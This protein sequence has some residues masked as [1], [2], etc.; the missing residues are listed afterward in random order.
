MGYHVTERLDV[1]V[2]YNVMWWT[3]VIRAGDQIDTRVNTALIPPALGTGPIPTTP[4]SSS[5]VWVQ[6][7][8]FGVMGRF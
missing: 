2:G 1:F 3:N 6:G 8:S 5:T 7:I 4:V